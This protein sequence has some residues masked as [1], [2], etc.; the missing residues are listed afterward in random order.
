MDGGDVTYVLTSTSDNA[1]VGIGTEV[2]K[3]KEL[4]SI[5]VKAGQTV[6]L[7]VGTVNGNKETFDLIC[8]T[9]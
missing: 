9:A 8:R 2:F 5:T 4:T 1:S 7:R 6:V 3:G